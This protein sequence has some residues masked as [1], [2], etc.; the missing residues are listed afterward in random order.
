MKSPLMNSIMEAREKKKLS[1]SQRQ[2][3]IKLIEKKERDKRFIKNWGPISL[4]NVDYKI[5]AKT[6]ATKLKETLLKLMSFQQTAYV[7]NRSISE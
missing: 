4:L 7:K 5:I 1:T 2:A 6:L 3:V